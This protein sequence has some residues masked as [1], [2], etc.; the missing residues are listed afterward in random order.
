[1]TDWKSTLRVPAIL[2]MAVLTV[3]IAGADDAPTVAEQIAG[4]QAMCADSADARAQRQAADPLYNRLGGY[5][6]IL[7]FTTE[8]VRLHNQNDAIQWHV[9]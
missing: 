2:M 6:K 3:T 8:V 7:E 4:M 9:H 1:M 5:D